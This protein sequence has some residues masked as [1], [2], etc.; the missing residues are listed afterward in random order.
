MHFIRQHSTKEDLRKNIQRINGRGY[1]AY[2]DLEGEYNFGNWKLYLDH[3]Q[4]DPFASPSRLRVRV[5]QT[6]AKFPK[7]LFKNHIRRIALQDY[8]ARQFAQAIRKFVKGRR[9][10]GKSGLVA[11]DAG[12]QEILERTAVIINEEF[13]EAR[14]VVGLPAHGRTVLGRECEAILLNELPR[15]VEASLQYTSL[16]T[17][18]IKEFIEIAEDQEV[19]RKTL[20]ELGLVAFV[21]NGS[22]LPRRSGISDEPMRGKGEVVFNSPPELE[23]EIDTINHGKIKGMG[24]P[25]GITLIV[26]GG[27]HGKSTLLRA[28]E[29]GIYNHIPGDGREWV[30]TVADAVKIRA[31]EGRQVTCVDI[32][33]FINNLPYGKNTREF[34]TEEASGSTSQ[35]ANIIE[36]LEIGTRLLLLDEDTSATNFMIRDV[37]MQHLVNKEKEPIT[38]F[39]DKVELLYRDQ[40][41]SSILVVG[42]SGDYFDVATRVIMMDEYRPYD[43]THL[44]QQIAKEIKTGRLKEGGDKFT[45][46]SARVP[47]PESFNAVK[48]RKVK[49][50]ARGLKTIQFGG[51]NIDL[52]CVEQLVDISQTRAIGSF[53]Y[54]VSRKYCNGRRTLTELINLGLADVQ[55]Y[56]LDVLA[57]FPGQHPGELALPRAYEI[58]AAINRLRILQIVK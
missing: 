17:S 27:Y 49:I 26:G 43:V 56:G 33:P 10:T 6:M 57:P 50:E 14:L 31:E 42:G 55:K 9:G 38:P 30:V 39:I 53:I 47:I 8:L 40:G 37:R 51:T 44:A 16:S 1:K 52:Q 34:F 3:A 28:I 5:P 21:G 12:A 41:V 24:V 11:I 15:V 32:Q 58:A 36:A 45:L 18:E 20:P 2:K 19:I 4:G 35:A 25:E 22:V 13:V 46:T 54:Y 7:E 29:R 23:V 48:G